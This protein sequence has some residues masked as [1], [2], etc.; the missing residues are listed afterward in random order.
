VHNREQ[1]EQREQRNLPGLNVRRRT[2]A[3]RQE[4]DL[5]SLTL[6][7]IGSKAEIYSKESESERYRYYSRQ[8]LGCIRGTGTAWYVV[9]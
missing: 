4:S 6:T 2:S 5:I 7:L 9:T 1:R 8:V 3:V